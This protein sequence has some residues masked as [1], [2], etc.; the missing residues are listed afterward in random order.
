M[1]KWIK[2]GVAKLNNMLNK[3][4]SK[5]PSNLTYLEYL[6]DNFKGSK[7][8]EEQ[9]T[10]VKYYKGEH[11]ILHRKKY[12][13]MRDNVKKELTNVP[14][15]KRIDN[16]YAKAVD[17]KV[18]Y[19]LGK[20]PMY[21]CE[22]T[23]YLDK[24]SAVLDVSFH[25]V[26]KNLLKD[27][28]NCGISWLYIYIDNESKMKYKRLP[29]HQ[30]CPI[31]EDEEHTRL[32]FAFRLYSNTEFINGAEKTVEY[33]D[34]YTKN[35]IEKYKLDGKTL[36]KIGE[37]SYI[38]DIKGNS[39]NWND[40]IPLVAFKYNDDEIPLIRRV[41]SLQD[42]INELMSDFNNNMEQDGRNTI[43]VIKN[44][45]GQGL[46]EFK[47]NLA[48]FGAIKVSDDGGVETLTVEVNSENYKSILDLYKNALIENARCYDAKDDRLNGQPNQMNIQSMY[49]DIDLDA[50]GIEVEYKGSFS[51][52]QKLLRVYLESVT[53][54]ENSDKDIEITFNKDV[55]INESQVIADVKNSVGVI[56]NNTLIKNH[57][58]VE[59]VDE[60]IQNIEEE[61]K[62]DIQTQAELDYEKQLGGGAIEK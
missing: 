48:N 22:D 2:K 60:E 20:I 36:N 47:N 33:V 54:F 57:P 37:E 46:E 51:Y 26:L 42:A 27:S 56:S 59:D 13:H 52:F 50:N 24:A 55:L 10:G 21:E 58:Y 32:N 9:I 53:E 62:K 41:K 6:V 1:F 4:E 43:L 25:K 61:K 39:Y 31:W 19:M 17:Q 3:P 35:S 44:Y 29:A 5:D 23:T 38:T 16:Q 45:E 11:D 15:N 18:N 7:I 28:L 34:V 8:R 14:N 40:R 30:I 49:S 12:L